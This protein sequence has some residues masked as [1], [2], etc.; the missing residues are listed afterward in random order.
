M[1]VVAL[2]V[3]LVTVAVYVAVR[4]IVFGGVQRETNANFDLLEREAVPAFFRSEKEQMERFVLAQTGRM[5]TVLDDLDGAA[6]QPGGDTLP[7]ANAA[8]E[9]SMRNRESL[10]GLLAVGDD[11]ITAEGLA[12][13][14]ADGRVAW[15]KVWRSTLYGEDWSR[16]PLVAT[17]PK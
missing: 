17:A 9:K 5:Q 12:F 13:I 4:R 11:I 2:V 15:N 14:A 3:L 10:G 1:S 6:H 7:A 16:F 8:L